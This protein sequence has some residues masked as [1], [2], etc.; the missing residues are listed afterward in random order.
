MAAPM[1]SCLSAPTTTCRL[2]STSTAPHEPPAGPVHFGRS[3]APVETYERSPDPYNNELLET[4]AQHLKTPAAKQALRKRKQYVELVIADAKVRQGMDRAQRR[5][6]ENM[7]MQAVL[8]AA[9][10]NLL[11]LAQDAR[12]VGEGVAALASTSSSEGNRHLGRPLGVLPG[13][14]TSDPCPASPQRY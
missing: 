7:L 5:G 1:A 12:H 3:A 8:T 14:L 6:R 2:S 10:M 13:R 4:V 11:K 9:T